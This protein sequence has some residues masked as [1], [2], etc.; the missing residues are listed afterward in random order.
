M[1]KLNDYC[2]LAGIYGIRILLGIFRVFKIHRRRIMF[3]SFVGKQYSCNPR[4][5]SET[6]QD[7]G[8]DYDIIWA[9]K[10]PSQYENLRENGITTCKFRSLAFYY[11]KFTSHVSVCNVAWGH[12]VYK[13][14]GQYEIN[15]F[16]GGCGGYKRSYGNDN[17]KSKID[18]YI[19]KHIDMVRY[20]LMLIST[21]MSLK[22]NV[23]NACGLESVECMKGTPRID[24]II[25]GGRDEI[26]K[27]VRSFCGI[28]SDIH[29]ALY[30]PTYRKGFAASDYGLDYKRL[31]KALSERFSG[32][33]CILLRLHPSIKSDNFFAEG[34]IDVTN[35]PDMQDLIYTSDVMLTDYSSCLWDFSFTGRP[36]FLYCTDLNKYLIER[37]FYT[38]IHTWGFPVCCSN[39]ELEQSILA[40]DQTKYHDAMEQH[41]KNMISYEDGKACQRVCAR[42]EKLCQE[43]KK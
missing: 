38:P 26:K 32:Q 25:N 14:K 29:I 8:H 36:C 31:K 20:D 34:V 18:E 1:S 5:I 9:F 35:Y 21:E 16:H 27:N 3:N 30:A 13:R 24:M 19:L 10:N 40:F 12:E 17:T 2:K 23:R 37:D 33:W 41:H 39:D 15:T 11:Y 28:L 43:S 22:N 7:S 42:I 4:A 6:L